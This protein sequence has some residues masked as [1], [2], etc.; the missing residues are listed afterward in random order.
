MEK[1]PVAFHP[2]RDDIGCAIRGA[3]VRYDNLGLFRRSRLTFAGQEAVERF[4]DKTLLGVCVYR[5]GE[6]RSAKRR[7]RVHDFEFP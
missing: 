2:R 5:D 3:V 7:P 1:A 6:K 4:P